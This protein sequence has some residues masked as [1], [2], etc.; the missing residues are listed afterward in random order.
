MR[1][2]LD[3][4][5]AVTAARAF[6]LMEGAHQRERLAHAFLVSGPAGS[7]KRDLAA[8]V[9]AMVN[10]PGDSGGTDLFG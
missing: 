8:R 9:I 3:W 7:G 6:E 4:A 2:S 5:M 10:P 1:D